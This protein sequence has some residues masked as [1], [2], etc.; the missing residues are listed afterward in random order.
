MLALPGM[1]HAAAAAATGDVEFNADFLQSSGTAKADISRFSKDN[2][3]PAGDYT[4]DLR[5]N[6][7]WRERA[8]LRFTVPPGGTN[9]KPCLTL[10]TLMRI[11]L[12]VSA[13][14]PAQRPAS[15]H[16]QKY[17]HRHR[18]VGNPN[19]CV[20]I[21]R[22]VPGA[23]VSFDMA[24]L[25]LSLSLPQAVVR[26][27]PT[28]YVSPESWAKG[29]N[30]FTLAYDANVFHTT[31][32][33][34]STTSV[35]A[36]LTAGLNIGDWHF[37]D[38]SALS[39]TNGHWTWQ[40]IAAYVE[41]DL[42]GLQ[43]SLT[44]GDAFTDGAV[45]DSVGFRGVALGT[46][47]RMRPD[48][49]TGYAPVV[50]GIARTNA[51]VRITQHGAVLLETTVAPGAF[52]IADLY[53][54]GYGGDLLVTVYESD[55]SQ[56]SFTVTY[57]SLVQL[58]RPHIWRYSLAAGNLQVNGLRTADRFIQGAVQHGISDALTTY[59]GGQTAAGY[60]AV[61]VGTALNTPLGGLALDA[62][63]ARTHLP[64]TSLAPD[65]VRQG[66]SVRLSYSKI[67]PGI[68]TNIA[69]SAY[70]Y[71]SGGFWS[72]QDAMAN[73]DAVRENVGLPDVNASTVAGA[74]MR[75]HS[76]FQINVAQNLPK[77]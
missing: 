29:V 54:T 41:R 75:Q 30:S 65:Q 14:P 34:I 19:T 22:V 15:W 32:S 49:M 76:R 74:I 27:R 70:R 21:E 9:A 57:S 23:T 47:D 50:R 11:G 31:Y 73:R 12:N 53:P 37:R 42:P 13:I 36:G 64:A 68:R 52:E 62:T 60:G 56:Q 43:S 71:S 61:L 3:V 18:Y 66:Y 44:V 25:T 51:R 16:R 39:G 28:G 6:G 58:L 8:N 77:H 2:V 5:V 48:S 33:G 35:Y 20:D 4:V 45:F 69:L 63:L 26:H 55:G 72:L 10:P 1:V 24:T 59:A 17:K 46:D 40:N 67:V 38:R 7:D